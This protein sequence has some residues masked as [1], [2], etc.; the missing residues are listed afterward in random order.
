VV[1]VDELRRVGAERAARRLGA[2]GGIVVERLLESR[3]LADAAFD[4]IEVGIDRTVENHGPDSLGKTLGVGRTE[5]GAVGEAEIVDLV[6]AQR[7]SDDV[8]V[9]RSRRGAHVGEELAAHSVDAQPRERGVEPLDVLDACRAVVGQRLATE[10][11]EFFIGAATQ[12]GC[13]MPDAARVDAD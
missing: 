11:I 9:A 5:F 3:V 6:F 4:R 8:H 2:V 12:F 13:R 10:R 7:G 1:A